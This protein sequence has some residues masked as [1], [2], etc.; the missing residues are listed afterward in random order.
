[1]DDLFDRYGHCTPKG[2]KGW[3]TFDDMLAVFNDLDPDELYDEAFDNAETNDDRLDI[4]LKIILHSGKRTDKHRF[5]TTV[6]IGQ[7][8]TTNIICRVIV[9]GIPS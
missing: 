3:S 1:M 6:W 7:D 4:K 2:I 8:I 9:L 5:A